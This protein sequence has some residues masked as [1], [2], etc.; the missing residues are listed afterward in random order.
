MVT[1]AAGRHY[2]AGRQIGL[3]ILG[4]KNVGRDWSNL[5]G[6][7]VGRND[8]AAHKVVPG[9]IPRQD[10]QNALQEDPLAGLLGPMQKPVPKLTPATGL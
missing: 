6:Q 10:W 7:Y 4:L 9:Y 5:A 3:P 2:P 1:G 8:S